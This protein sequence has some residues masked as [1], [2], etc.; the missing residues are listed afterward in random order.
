MNEKGIKRTRLYQVL[1][2]V[3]WENRREEEEVVDADDGCRDAMAR[4]DEGQFS[5]E[6]FASLLFSKEKGKWK[7][8]TLLSFLSTRDTE[9]DSDVLQDGPSQVVFAAKRW[10]KEGEMDGKNSSK[11]RWKKKGIFEAIIMCQRIWNNNTNTFP[12]RRS[13][14]GWK[15]KVAWHDIIVSRA[16][17]TPTSSERD[18][19]VGITTNIISQRRILS[20]LLL[21]FPEPSEDQNER[22]YNEQRAWR[23]D[24]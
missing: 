8:N 21:I 9:I 2:H 13:Q 24:M 10:E 1:S 14:G 20:T 18:F 23:R 5:K 6:H 7:R 12:K 4:D 17:T 15:I 3:W 16:S 11:V 19:H 22:G